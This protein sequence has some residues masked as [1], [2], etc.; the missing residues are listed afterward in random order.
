MPLSSANMGQPT[1]GEEVRMRKTILAQKKKV[2]KSLENF[3]WSVLIREDKEKL[4]QMSICNS[5]NQSVRQWPSSLL[6]LQLDK[7]F[8]VLK[9]EVRKVLYISFISLT[10]DSQPSPYSQTIYQS[11]Q[12]SFIWNNIKSTSLI[13]LS[14]AVSPQLPFM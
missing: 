1:K 6:I 10:L 3:A 2:N 13:S 14:L 4:S 11:T 5:I 8:I 12:K 9:E 7:W